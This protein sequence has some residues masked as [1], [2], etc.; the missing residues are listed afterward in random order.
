M[1]VF[2]GMRKFWSLLRLLGAIVFGVAAAMTVVQAPIIPLFMVALVATEFG[3]WLFIIPLVIAFLPARR[4]PLN[5]FTTALA[6]V[7]SVLLLSPV[8]RANAVARHLPEEL[9]HAFP[10]AAGSNAESPAPFSWKQLWFGSQVEPVAV[11]KSE[12]ATHADETLHLLFY[13]PS[14]TRPATCVIVIHGGGWINGSATEG[15]TLNHYLARRGFAS[16]AIEYRFAPRWTWPAQRDDV[17]DAIE[18]LKKHATEL[19]I[20]PHRFVLLGRSAGGQIAEAV[21]YG[22]HDPAIRGCIAFYAPADMHYAYQFARA[23]DILNSLQLVNQY[24]GGTPTEAKANY[25][26]ASSILLAQH[27]S[28][29]T[30]LIHGQRDELV[31]F[32]QDERLSARLDLLG[33]P[34]YFVRLPWATHAFDA[35]FNGPGGQI[36][37][38]AV[39]AFLRSVTQ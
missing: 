35:N 14:G 19:G 24:L 28:P 11:E 34:H 13:R 31:W 26:S 12:Y 25:D 5:C 6:L 10:G 16:A 20:D 15:A 39:E 37:T 4:T 38:Y 8:N 1:R 9:A 7:S 33:A 2:H 22:A 32:R 17:L 3:H 21:A 36:S 27:D 30:L 29:P 18:Y 23:D